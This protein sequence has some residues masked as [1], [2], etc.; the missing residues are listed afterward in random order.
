MPSRRRRQPSFC[1][2]LNRTFFRRRIMFKMVALLGLVA[3]GA[4]YG[5]YTH[6]DLFCCKGGHGCCLLP[7]KPCCDDAATPSPSCCTAGSECCD[8][9]AECCLTDKH[10]TAA[11]KTA[12]GAKAKSCC[13]DVCCPAC[14]ACCSDCCGEVCCPVCP[15]CC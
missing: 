9:S 11:S 4:G 10:A 7:N 3:G 14:P 13:G 2:E 15:A 6:T 5:L 12:S 1:C 8:A